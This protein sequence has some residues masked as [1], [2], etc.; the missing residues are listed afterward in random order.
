M[1]TDEKVLHKCST[2]CISGELAYGRDA[3]H[4]SRTQQALNKTL[5]SH[6]EQRPL[7]CIIVLGK[8][9]VNNW[10]CVFANVH[11]DSLLGVSLY[12]LL[13]CFLQTVCV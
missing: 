4:R 11:V 3:K 9:S 1:E 8:H 7:L 2:D 5:K 13:F 12:H 10:V 6:A